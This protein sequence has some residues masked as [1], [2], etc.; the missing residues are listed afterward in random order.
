VRLNAYVMHD[1]EVEFRVTIP[2]IINLSWKY[3]LSGRQVD[4]KYIT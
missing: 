1:R 4:G 3:S 2:S